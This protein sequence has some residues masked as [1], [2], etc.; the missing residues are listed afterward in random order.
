[1]KVEVAILGSPS[2]IILKVSVEIKQ[3]RTSVTAQE[4][5]ES[6]GGRPG[7]PVPDNPCRLCGRKG[8]CEEDQDEG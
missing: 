6:G 3:H 1:M 8:R 4:L 7:L 5:C 2:L